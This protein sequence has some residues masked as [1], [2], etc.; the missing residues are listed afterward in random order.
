[1]ISIEQIEEFINETMKEYYSEVEENMVNWQYL[2]NASEKILAGEEFDD[3]ECPSFFLPNIQ[4]MKLIMDVTSIDTWDWSSPDIQ[5]A[6]EKISNSEVYRIFARTTVKIALAI[7]RKIEIGTIV[8]VGTGHGQVT[9]ML[10]NELT[11]SSLNIPLVISDRAPS[12][13]LVEDQLHSAFPDLPIKSFIWDIGN[14]PPRDLI[15]SLR[16]PIFLFER[17]CIPYG[18]YRAIHNIAPIADIM[19][20]V[21]DLN[22]T[23]EKQAFD[24][25]FEKIGLEFFTFNETLKHLKQHFSIIYTCDSKISQTMGVPV[26]DF[27]LA[28]R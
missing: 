15:K 20:M 2:I 10:C 25:I 14:E 16:P 18:G 11:K 9:H 26:T 22:L 19:L 6:F 24:L 13:A 12:I 5:K 8:E 4:L 1:M 23:G 28:I 3:S 17:F 7:I 27:T 21:E